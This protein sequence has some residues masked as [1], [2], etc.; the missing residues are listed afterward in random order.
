VTDV[1]FALGVYDENT[2]DS[3]IFGM[4]QRWYFIYHT[5]YRHNHQ[6]LFNLNA[7]F[8]LEYSKTSK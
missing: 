8:T 4:K 1:D 6:F 2:Q 5:T 7:N 3:S